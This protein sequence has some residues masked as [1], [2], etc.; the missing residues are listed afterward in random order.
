MLPAMEARIRAALHVKAFL[1]TGYTSNETGA[2]GFQCPHLPTSHFHVHENMTHVGIAALDGETQERNVSEPQ[3]RAG[4]I[5]A[6]NLNRTLMPMVRYEIGDMGYIIKSGQAGGMRD[7]SLDPSTE[8]RDEPHQ[9]QGPCL[10]GRRL[11]V[12]RLLGRCDSRIR[13][14]GEDL[15]LDEIPKC[16]AQVRGVSLTFSLHISKSPVR[17]F[18]HITLHVEALDLA[19]L[20]DDEEC[21]RISRDVVVQLGRQTQLVWE[22]SPEGQGA[23]EGRGD[24]G[25]AGGDAVFVRMMTKKIKLSE[26]C[27]EVPVVEVHGPNTLPRNPRTGKI[28]LLVDAR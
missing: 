24:G 6:T 7:S 4:K 19:V 16:L 14:G 11:R 22:V 21:S 26:A 8:R 23:D 15:F 1:S 28:Q 17:Q 9:S 27:V 12:L 3:Q 2:I 18:D 13:L 5:V 20:S 10:C 25:T